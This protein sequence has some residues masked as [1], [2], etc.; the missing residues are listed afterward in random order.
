[1]ARSSFRKQIVSIRKLW[2]NAMKD[3]SGLSWSLSYGFS[4]IRWLT[5]KRLNPAEYLEL[6][7]K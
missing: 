3:G 2:K 4:A 5:G 6:V 1:M 7:R